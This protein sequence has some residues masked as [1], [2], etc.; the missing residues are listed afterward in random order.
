MSEV[1]NEHAWKANPTALR[2]PTRINAD[3]RNNLPL[4]RSTLISVPVGDVFE[5]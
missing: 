1:V 2:T 5:G 3:S 4:Q